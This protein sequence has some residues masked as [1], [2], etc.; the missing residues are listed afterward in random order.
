MHSEVMW[1]IKLLCRDES[2]YERYEALDLKLVQIPQLLI[3]I[4]FKSCSTFLNVKPTPRNIVCC[5]I[6]NNIKIWSEALTIKKT[7]RCVVRHGLWLVLFDQLYMIK[8]PTISLLP[9][10]IC[11]K[12][13][14]EC[15][16]TH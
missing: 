9:W 2:R 10:L 15:T 11:Q 1:L 12:H 14:K 3:I 16:S 7:S 5:F 13:W 4:C 6:F 8:K